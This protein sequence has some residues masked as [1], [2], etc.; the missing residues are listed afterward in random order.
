GR[1]QVSLLGFQSQIDPDASWMISCAQRAP[2]GFNWARYCNPALE[3]A[4]QRGYSAYDRV[5][6]RREYSFVQRQ[7]LEDMPYAFLWQRSEVDVIPTQ[8]KGFM[9]PAYLSAYASSAGWH[10]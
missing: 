6:R 2:N 9:P 1:Y 5:A 8:L 3:R 10:W 4:L 7:L